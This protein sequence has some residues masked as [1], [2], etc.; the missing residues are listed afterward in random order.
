MNGL[1]TLC[2]LRDRLRLFFGSRW[3]IALVAVLI[4]LG[5]TTV[6]VG[7][8][9]LLGGYQEF[10]FGGLM[11]L[12]LCAAC[13]V[14]CDL[15]F[16]IMPVISFI[17]LVPLEHSP[18]VPYHSRFYIEPLPL[19]L[20]IVL[21]VLLIGCL[22][23]FCVR[24]RH[25]AKRVPYARPVF[26][27]MAVFCGALFLN[28]AFS[29]YYTV[30]DTVYPV[31]FALSLLLIYALFAAY[32]RFDDTAFDYFMSC[33]VGAGLLI[34][35]ELL[36][37]YLTGGVRFEDGRVVKESVML[38]W[39]V[40]T[41]IGG[42]LAFLM[43]ACFYF[44]YA[45]R[46]G[47]IFFLLG[48]L[49]YGCIL[50]SQSR[51]GLLAGSAVLALCLLRLC[52]G[53]PNR[54][55]NRIFTAVLAAAGLGV[56]ALFSRPLIGVVQNYLAS[57]LDDNGRFDL[58][59]R[60]WENFLD[61]PV[62]GAGF[63]NSLINEDWPKEVYPYLYHNTVIQLMASG[64]VVALGAY[65]WHR[66][67]TLRL[68]LHRPNVRKTFLALGILALLLF[69]LLDVLFFNTY[70]TIIYALMLLCME[71]SADLGAGR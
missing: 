70:P 17:F 2:R 41:A 27:S 64:G 14:C 21:A 26:L 49:E 28:G 39:G 10:L 19:T 37:A 24:N 34:C 56:A 51:G 12:S 7:G 8:R 33:L 3:Y 46:R 69:S 52:L 60:G 20:L 25:I 18:N 68:A 54:R 58:W 45:H 23:W 59:R 30:A 42:M 35:A 5:H 4:L 50:L 47:W 63:Y 22:V 65:L 53:G 66:F 71:K 61:Y 36:L 15:R 40:W 1:Q 62:F 13:F 44:A 31:S 9:P 16:L 38:G 6:S 57:G 43:P 67:C 48:L 55:Q 29:S 11:V 32:T